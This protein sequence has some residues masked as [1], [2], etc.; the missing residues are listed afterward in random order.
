MN[1]EQRQEALDLADYD[2]PRL[3]HAEILARNARGD[4]HRAL[5]VAKGRPAYRT[6]TQQQRPDWK[7]YRNA[8]TVAPDPILDLLAL[9]SAAT[10][11]R[12]NAGAALRYGELRQTV[13][14]P[15]VL[16]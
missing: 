12:F 1:Y 5:R 11:R 15:V 13:V 10:M 14:S 8:P 6:A 2:E 9:R 16:P 7:H 4:L 3:S